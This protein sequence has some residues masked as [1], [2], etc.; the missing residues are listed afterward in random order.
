MVRSLFFL[1]FLFFIHHL[2]CTK[3]TL[4]LLFSYSLQCGKI[5]IRPNAEGELVE[6]ESDDEEDYGRLNHRVGGVPQPDCVIQ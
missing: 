6:F 1:C 4:L 3:L 5:P 2:A